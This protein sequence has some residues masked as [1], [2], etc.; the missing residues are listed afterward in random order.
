MDTKN[1]RG[2]CIVEAALALTLIAMVVWFLRDDKKGWRE[3]K[4]AKMIP[5]A[6]LSEER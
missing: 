4:A 1:S 6:Q 5:N 3:P 2:Q